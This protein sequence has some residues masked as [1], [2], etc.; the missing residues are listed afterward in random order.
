MLRTEGPSRATLQEQNALQCKL[1]SSYT[2]QQQSLQETISQ[3]E[4]FYAHHSVI[5]A[6]KKLQPI[7]PKQSQNHRA[8]SD[9]S[10]M[11]VHYHPLWAKSNL[12]KTVAEFCANPLW[13]NPIASVI[14]KPI[15]V[16]I[17]WQVDAKN[18]T[19]PREEGRGL[20]RQATTTACVTLL[21]TCFDSVTCI[22]RPY[23]F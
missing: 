16:G 13:H 1:C 8:N 6:L 15:H 7:P 18:Q 12:K 20:R 9:L 17:A 22:I 5:T 3:F 23:P 2:L 10:W 19:Q 21:V 4:R 14:G 11:R